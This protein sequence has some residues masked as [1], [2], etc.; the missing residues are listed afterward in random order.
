M[1]SVLVLRAFSRL[2]N[3]KRRLEKMP[4]ESNKDAG[5]GKKRNYAPICKSLQD[6][7]SISVRCF[8]VDR[9]FYFARLLRERNCPLSIKSKIFFNK[10]MSD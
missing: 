6:E 5:F 8:E 7:L 10:F 3:Q 9:A 4:Y 1:G 2:K